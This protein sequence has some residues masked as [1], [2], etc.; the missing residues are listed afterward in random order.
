MN[1]K[2]T[3]WIWTIIEIVVAFTVFFALYFSSGVVL[4]PNIRVEVQSYAWL[5][6]LWL[7]IFIVGSIMIERKKMKLEE[8]KNGV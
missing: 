6:F 2:M 7:T 3:Y 8:V 1:K 5:P 4:P